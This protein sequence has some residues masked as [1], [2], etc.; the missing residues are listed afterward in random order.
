MNFQCDI[1]AKS[2]AKL[3]FVESFYPFKNFNDI[4][5]KT[6]TKKKKKKKKGRTNLSNS[7]PKI[8]PV[9]GYTLNGGGS[10]L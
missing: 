7:Y 10:V 8:I 2:L 1:I 5:G 3:H 4:F 6:K 9:N